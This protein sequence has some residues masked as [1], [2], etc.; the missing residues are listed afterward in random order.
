MKKLLLCQC[1][2]QNNALFLFPD[3]KI[4]TIQRPGKFSTE[5]RSDLSRHNAP[6]ATTLGQRPVCCRTKKQ[7]RM[8][9]ELHQQNPTIIC[10]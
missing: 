6:F 3:A 4:R 5:F 10:K 9:N 7:P 2:S 8:R 1:V